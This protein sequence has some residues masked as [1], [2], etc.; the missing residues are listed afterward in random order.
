[1]MT[2]HRAKQ[3]QCFVAKPH[4]ERRTRCLVVLGLPKAFGAV[5]VLATR[6]RLTRWP[7]LIGDR[8]GLALE[9][10]VVLANVVQ[11]APS[12]DSKSQFFTAEFATK[13]RS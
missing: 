7:D 2:T 8:W 6:D 9:P 11:G 10:C 12:R 5:V 3:W 4:T 1:M 13:L